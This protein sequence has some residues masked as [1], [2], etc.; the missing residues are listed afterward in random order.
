MEDE[1]EKSVRV[2][3]TDGPNPNYALDG[4]KP[5]HQFMSPE[6]MGKLNRHPNSPWTWSLDELIEYR[7]LGVS[8][9][10]II[11]MDALYLI[12]KSGITLKAAA[13]LFEMAPQSLSQE[14][15]LYNAFMRGQA[16]IGSK[17]RTTLVGE[18]LENGNIQA[19]IHLDK[20]F[21]A[22]PKTSTQDVNINITTSEKLLTISTEK[23]LEVAFNEIHDDEDSDK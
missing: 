10:R 6:T 16:E 4:M 19:Q 21:N 18:A 14:K 5:R 7:S 15:D 13:E 23:L 2:K 17:I 11:N 3:K 9:K 12:G 22:E 1:S 8:P 20:V